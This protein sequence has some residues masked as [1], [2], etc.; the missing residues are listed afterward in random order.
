MRV[1]LSWLREYVDVELPTE[2]LA[3]RLTLAGL[4]VAAIHRIGVPGSPVPWDPERVVVGELR[5]VGPHP[6]ADRLVLA[7]VEYGGGRTRQVVTGAPNLRVGDAGQKVAFALEGARLRD[8]YAATPQVVT[9]AGRK[10]RGVFSDAMILSEKELGL[11]DDH[12]GVLIL[13][14]AAPVGVS[15]AAY[16]GDEVLDIEITPNMA[17][18]LSLLGVAREVAALT[19]AAVRLPAAGLHAQGG[20]ISAR[21][22][23]SVAD[24]ERSARY[25]ATLVEAVRVGPSPEWM[26]RRLR[27]AGI[28]PISNVVDITNYV[29]LEWGQPLHAFDYDALVRRAGGGTPHIT[30][31]A[32]E[33]GEV[34]VTLDG[35]RRVLDPERLVI[36]DAAGAV[37]VAGV[38]GGA[39]TEVTPGTSRVLLE[40]A[41]FNFISIRKT[42]QALKLPSEASARFGRGVSPALAVP[43]AL[44]ATALLQELGGGTAV[45][46]VA[47]CYPRQYVPPTVD[48]SLA[49]VR[50]ILGISPS[51]EEVARLLTALDFR[52]ETSGDERLRVR[53]P[54]YR[55]DIG[56]GVVGVADLL[57]E[58]ARLT[59]YD[60]MPGT[61]MADTLPPQRNNP[62]VELEERVRDCLVTAGLQEVITY[63]LTTPRREAALRPGGGEEGD[64][65]RLANPISADRTVLRRT[66]LH[67]VLEVLAL[68]ARVR[69]RLWCFEVGPVF[70]PAVGLPDEPRRL[71]VGLRGPVAPAS[72]LAPAPDLADFY[73]LKGVLEA[74]LGALHV[75]AAA[76][77]P[78]SHPTFAPGRTAQLLLEGKTLGVLGEVRPEVAAAFDLPAG[79]PVCLA[80]LDLEALL[81]Q[82]TPGFRVA[83][84][85][86]FPPAL[87]D[88]AVVLDEATPAAELVAVIRSAGGPLLAEVRV[89]DVYRGRQVAAGKKS[90]ALS[91]AF[92]AAD[93][94]LTDA[95]VQAAKR[96]IV[97]ALASRLAATLRA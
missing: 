84:V 45:P 65:V 94:T 19:G 92:Q 25:A 43:A 78:G 62:S 28:R 29:M 23:V 72:W 88:L 37:A 15:L 97:D 48:L 59:G 8:A 54:E 34:L 52:C 40:A 58:V 17:R 42:T 57:E 27:L 30:V 6:N 81:R 47:D 86:R 51:R 2:A 14:P 1:P 10:V 33:P 16:L 11:S 93:R 22:R 80:E 91:L 74:L 18:C 89:F 76:F 32:A 75:E 36:A 41:N 50:R 3:E 44:R 77:E 87:Q 67:G 70:L 64:Y 79:P 61:E 95:E 49:E 63:R 66:L 56:E 90:L 85:P 55:L 39:E 82:A 96:R 21:V 68:N 9:L 83:P 26:R 46:G 12:E 13:D 73:A 53:T 4:E 20:T 69:D 7:T 31:R 35:E 60:R 38:M 24:P 5:S 71:A